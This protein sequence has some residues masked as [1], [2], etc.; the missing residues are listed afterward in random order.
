MALEG[1]AK[2][3][4]QAV[5]PPSSRRDSFRFPSS[6]LRCCHLV[7][8]CASASVSKGSVDSFPLTRS[9]IDCRREHAFRGRDRL[10][11]HPNPTNIRIWHNCRRATIELP[12]RGSGSCLQCHCLPL[13]QCH[14]FRTK[15]S[16]SRVP[17]LDQ[18]I[19][20]FDASPTTPRLSHGDA[21]PDHDARAPQVPV[22]GQAAS[23]TTTDGRPVTGQTTWEELSDA[24]KQ[25]LLSLEERIMSQRA[26]MTA[27]LG[28][29]STRPAGPSVTSEAAALRQQVEGARSA[30]E[31]DSRAIQA[32]TARVRETLQCTEAAIRL[33]QRVQMWVELRSQRDSGSGAGLPPHVLQELALRHALPSEAL[34]MAVSWFEDLVKQYDAYLHSLE[35]ALRAG[36]GRRGLGATP[37]QVGIELPTGGGV[38]SKRRQRRDPAAADPSADLRGCIAPSA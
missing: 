38:L 8:N 17:F 7:N 27:L 22:Q 4:L 23:L 13:C 16:G 28:V 5:S 12:L 21:I 31:A 3:A 33:A 9:S 2:T 14:G 1:S 26:D 19:N 35:A 30:L 10:A 25:W 6:L 18:S 32:V 34:P 11:R 37:A 36:H 20:T 15:R 24:S 29:L